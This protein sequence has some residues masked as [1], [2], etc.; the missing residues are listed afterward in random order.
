V[1]KWKNEERKRRQKRAKHIE[2]EIEKFEREPDEQA[3][4]GW[5]AAEAKRQAERQRVIDL[6]NSEIAR[7]RRPR[8][9]N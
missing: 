4:Q 5:A 3:Q 2:T 7:A 8:G 1:R 6:G 9:A